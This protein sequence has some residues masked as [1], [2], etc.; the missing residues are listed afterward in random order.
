MNALKKSREEGLRASWTAHHPARRRSAS[1]AAL[2]R[3]VLVLLVFSANSHAALP[4]RLVLLL[5]G[6][7]YGDMKAL[8][9]G[10]SYTDSRGR[11]LTRRGFDEGYFPPSR[12]I[13]TF[14]SASDV[15]WTEMLGNSP[16]PGY[17]RTYFDAATGSEVRQNG[18]TTTM[19][20]ERQM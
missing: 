15:A 7:S 2:V 6:V 18:V 4:T 11:R 5:A 9:E 1:L 14:P 3:L 10:A 8:Q 20:Y 12:M 13:S 16:L 17:Q 19:E